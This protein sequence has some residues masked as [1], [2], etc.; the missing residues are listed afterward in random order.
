MKEQ[1]I[2]FKVD[3]DLINALKKIPNRSEFIRNS[4]LKSLDNLCPLCNG[5]GIM[6]SCQKS[7]WETFTQYHHLEECKD[8][9]SVFLTCDK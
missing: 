5:T 7:H 3:S 8:C 9:H 4:I 1:I 2:T 6:S